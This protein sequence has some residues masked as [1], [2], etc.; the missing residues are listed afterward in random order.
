MLGRQQ[1]AGIP[2]AI[3]ELF[4]NAHDAYAHKVDVDFYRQDG[5]LLIRDDGYGMTKDDFES[6]WLTLGTESKIGANQP[7]HD[8]WTDDNKE[9]RR[10]IMGEK[11]IG[12]LAIAA[13]GP[14]VLILTRARRKSGVK[15]LVVSIVH[16]GL[17]E[18]PG[19]NLD[20]IEIPVEE[21]EDG[22]LPSLA[23]IGS[24]ID[25]VRK[26]V[27]DLGSAV[28]WNVAD[29]IG[30]DLELFRM[31]LAAIDSVA[32]GPRLG[33]DGSGTHF[34]I[35]P[36]Y[37]ILA[38]D[39]DGNNEETA[40][41]LEKMLLGFSNT[42]MPS[43][44]QPAIQ[45]EFRDHRP[46]GQTDELIGGRS[47]FTPDEFESA[48]H[49]IDGSFDDFGQFS[50]SISVYREKAVEHAIR[51]PKANGK[52]TECGPFR[53]KFAYL[54][55]DVKDSK[56]PPDLW[57]ELSAKLNKIG[58]LYVYRDGIRILPY[59]NSDY[60]FLNI[61]RRRT[62]SAQDW[63]F[64]YRRIFGA[65]E[66]SAENNSTLVEKAGREGFRTNAA[67]RELVSMLENCFER[68]AIDFFRETSKYGEAFN[69]TKEELQREAR[70]LK[71]R[72]QLT[73]G[74]RRAFSERLQMFFSDL[75]KGNAVR[76][77]DLIRSQT[78]QRLEAIRD[79]SD[80]QQAVQALLSVEADARI[81]IKQLE[82]SATITRP[83]GVGLTKSL[84]SDWNAY[85]RNTEKLH[86]EVISPLLHDVEAMVDEVV[87]TKK[88]ALDRR[89]R[90][91][92]VL[93]DSRR[94]ALS[95]S[96]KARRE[97]QEQLASLVST[98]E[99]HMKESVANLSSEIEKTF[100]SFE[101]TATDGM[102][103]AE[104]RAAQGHLE[105]RIIESASSETELLEGLRDQ[106]ASLVIS[107][108]DGQTLDATTA[109]LES[110]AES[111]R[112]QLDTYSDLAQ[113]GM[114]LS[115]VQHEFSSAVKGIRSAI[116]KLRPWA[117]GTP[118]L[119]TLYDE[120]R[121]GFDHLDGYLRLF[122][123]LSRRLNREA[124][125]MSGEEIRRYLI[126]VFDQR[127]RRHGIA[128]EATPSFDNFRIKAYPSTLLPSFVNVIDNAVY[129]IDSERSSEKLI[130]LDADAKGFI[131][132]NGGPGIEAR[133][134]DRIFDY[135]E[136]TKVG[137]RGIGLYLSRESLRRDGLDLTLESIGKDIHPVFRLGSKVPDAGVA[138]T[139]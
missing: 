2:T 9:P 101:Q 48:D 43:R 61:E 19:V 109:A 13:I 90:A 35:R 47:F 119:K 17:F 107:V 110:T 86:G 132:W 1:I 93:E 96:G 102:N 126:E 11:G 12:R 103:D 66:V 74:R 55:G 106:L 26:N 16:W 45:A 33:R 97:L 122:T 58:G 5:L 14:Q 20:C 30:Q 112:E 131:I 57:A 62:K 67:Y 138:V 84:N 24:L 4:K 125:E 98:V 36:V 63:F 44:Q 21:V 77:A 82:D 7:D 108:N 85:L 113:L 28:P 70:L 3:H 71:R 51:W 56:L 83:R 92:A 72:E 50:G 87:S 59:G 38:D 52:K 60:D 42:M 137:G 127:L 100:I 34:Y 75:E 22:E 31:D 23:L 49:H 10:P 37:P 136:T 88:L 53:I 76:Q 6:R 29:R 46:D 117:A 68:L 129:W 118:E 115:V 78:S 104:L 15:P 69:T 25:R 116:R 64:S 39:I 133:I 89:K 111:Y 134:A 120:L 18:L 135:G 27:S 94:L 99:M 54:Q 81:S 40:S 105:S 79:L 121:I 91:L 65:I 139:P 80:Q 8:V 32:I 73:K 95:R 124:V 123:P 128:I 130:K 114:A 41:P